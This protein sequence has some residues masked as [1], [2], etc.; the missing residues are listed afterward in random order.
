MKEA[1]IE[2][3]ERELAAT[4]DALHQEQLIRSR[5]SSFISVGGRLER[6]SSF[7][8]SGGHS[9][10]TSFLPPQLHKSISV[11][12]LDLDSGETNGNK[13]RV[14][15]LLHQAQEETSQQR[16]EI[17][18]VRMERDRLSDQ[19]TVLT[20][21]IARLTDDQ[22]ELRVTITNSTSKL[23]FRSEQL[24]TM[25]MDKGLAGSRV[26][27][28]VSLV[29]A[30]QAKVRHLEGDVAVT[31]ADVRASKA[32][33][34]SVEERIGELATSKGSLLQTRYNQNNSPLPIMTG[35]QTRSSGLNSC[36]SY[37]LIL[38]SHHI[39]SHHITSHHFR[40]HFPCRF[41]YFENMAESLTRRAE[42]AERALQAL[43]KASGITAEDN[44]GST[45][46]SLHQAVETG[47]LETRQSLEK[48]E[49]WLATL[50]DEAPIN[51]ASTPESSSSSSSSSVVKKG[52]KQTPSSSPT[53]RD[54]REK[55]PEKSKNGKNKD[56]APAVTGALVRSS[57]DSMN[58]KTT[59]KSNASIVANGSPKKVK[60]QTGTPGQPM[61]KKTTPTASS[62]AT[63]PT[64]T[65]TAKKTTT[66]AST[67][68]TPTTTTPKRPNTVS[69]TS[70]SP[71][72]HNHPA[73]ATT[74]TSTKPGMTNTT[75]TATS[76]PLPPPAT[77]PT[78]PPIGPPTVTSKGTSGAKKVP[79]NDR[80]VVT[81]RAIAN[82]NNNNN[83]NNGESK[84]KEDIKGKPR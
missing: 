84:K 73:S 19:V 80:S 5:S 44:Y 18:S 2:Q 83:N 65:K 31:T 12:F 76:T 39:T 74:A 14:M 16:R 22:T 72:S 79:G 68:T 51:A 20:R 9:S 70:R 10:P 41:D 27:D 71:S 78:T 35:Y 3:L 8:S 17:A 6:S 21:Q 69:S 36:A 75:N 26:A 24:T 11:D 29:T 48:L 23:R 13:N 33:V 53:A 34:Q 62:A 7:V 32:L 57:M 46:D 60:I 1:Q 66:T 52:A 58:S 43:M 82:N 28:L 42:K 63:T 25:E 81:G 64:T 15:E 50:P 49:K 37:I 4:V 61:E 30:A 40:S 56:A 54:N 55:S 77:K 38:T 59:T 47:L 45:Q 67:A